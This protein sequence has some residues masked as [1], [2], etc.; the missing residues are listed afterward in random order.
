MSLSGLRVEDDAGSLALRAHGGDR[1]AERELCARLGPAVR[2][3]ARR[4]LRGRAAVEDFTQDVMVLF[5]EALRD[6]RI[7]DPARAGGFALGICR[8]L[9]RD[10]ARTRDRRREVIER[11]YEAPEPVMPWEPVLF[12]RARL[13]D[14]V[15]QLTQR[16]RGVL[17]HSFG[18]DSPDAEIA[19]TLAITEANVRVIRHRSLAA[20][21]EC[22][23][24]TLS[25]ERAR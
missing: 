10:R 20:L 6:G 23:E 25:W 2:A 3:F 22:V 11:L 15:S 13:E 21:R 4:R 8:N 18:D 14:C 19:T 1:H 7:E 24:G 16:A 17:R 5:V 12:E 9:A